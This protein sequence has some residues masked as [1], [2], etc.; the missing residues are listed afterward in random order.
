MRQTIK[1]VDVFQ[2]DDSESSD[3]KTDHESRTTDSLE[4]FKWERGNPREKQS[5]ITETEYYKGELAGNHE[6]PALCRALLLGA[7]LWEPGSEYNLIFLLNLSLTASPRF[8]PVNQ[9]FLP[10]N[11]EATLC[12][13]IHCD[14]SLPVP[15]GHD[16]YDS[17]INPLTLRVVWFTVH[18]ITA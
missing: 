17:M 18:V 13:V 15:P 11:E 1:M 12:L 16:Y 8:V 6:E 5:S 3:L 7:I 9:L 10:E 4:G 14:F 2:C